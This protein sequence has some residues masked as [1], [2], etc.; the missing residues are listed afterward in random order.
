MLN[1]NLKLFCNLCVIFQ[2]GKKYPGIGVDEVRAQ[3]LPWGHFLGKTDHCFS[4][5]AWG[6]KD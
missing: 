2:E 5:G 4:N 3:L 1:K 6:L